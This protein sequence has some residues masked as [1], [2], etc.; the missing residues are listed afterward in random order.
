MVDAREILFIRQNAPRGL[1]RMVADN[2]G[3]KRHKV[4]NELNRLKEEY[5]EQIVTEARRLLKATKGLEYGKV[6]A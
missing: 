4:R 3:L 2:L 1:Y 6:S 5:D